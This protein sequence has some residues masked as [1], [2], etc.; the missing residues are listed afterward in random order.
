MNDLW[1]Q[2]LGAAKAKR[3]QARGNAAPIGSG[4]AGETCGSCVHCYSPP[5]FRTFYKCRLVKPTHGPGTDIRL[6]WAACARW[7]SKR[8]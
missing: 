5:A 1:N 7:Q 6:K 3:G 2:P 8:A 4:P